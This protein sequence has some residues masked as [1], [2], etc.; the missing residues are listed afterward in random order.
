V[1]LAA[2]ARRPI[3]MSPSPAILKKVTDRGSDPVT[4]RIPF[5]LLAS[6]LSGRFMA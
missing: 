1:K 3:L 5:P 2:T 4:M 6:C